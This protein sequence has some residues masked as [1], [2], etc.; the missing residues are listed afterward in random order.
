MRKVRI[1]SFFFQSRVADLTSINSNLTSIKNKLE[2]EL[3]TAQAD[4]DEVTKELHAADERANRAL[5]DAARAVEQLHE[6]QEHSM[7]IDALRKS[8]EEQV[9]LPFKS[10]GKH[11]FASLV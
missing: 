6:E 10:I 9:R 8:L 3:S 5:A 1:T 11:Y 4:L 7:K 2:T